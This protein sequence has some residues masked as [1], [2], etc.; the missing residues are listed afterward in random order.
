MHSMPSILLEA[1]QIINGPRRSDYGHPLDNHSLTGQMWANYLQRKYPG[2]RITA[3]DVCFMNILQKIARISS[4]GKVT[5][6]GITDIAGYAGNIE[7]INQESKRRSLDGGT[8]RR[9]E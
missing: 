9:S 6:D 3:E 7:M 5:R 1:E 2:L 8:E 4:T